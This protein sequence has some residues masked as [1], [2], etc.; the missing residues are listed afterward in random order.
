MPG[1]NR[2]TILS[3]EVRDMIN[4]HQTVWHRC[5]GHGAVRMYEYVGILDKLR[6]ILLFSSV[7]RFPVWV[8]DDALEC[9]SI[10]AQGFC[11]FNWR[12]R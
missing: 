12:P 1:E 11:L 2:G 6:R 4:R 9:L 7:S 8:D 5:P 3:E 10:D